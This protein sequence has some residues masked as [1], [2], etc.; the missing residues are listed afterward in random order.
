MTTT[1]RKYIG[2]ANPYFTLTDEQAGYPETR[3]HLAGYADTDLVREYLDTTKAS[4]NRMFGPVAR[5]WGNLVI[6][7]MLSRGITSIPNIFGAI[8]VRKFAR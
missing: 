4:F 8:E 5:R 2:A 6:E 3:R 1:T 7:E